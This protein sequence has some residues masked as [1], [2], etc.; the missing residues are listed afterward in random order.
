MAITFKFFGDPALTTE[1]TA[2]LTFSQSTPSPT[3]DD[4]VVYFGSA[5][6]G[7]TVK[8]ASDPGVDQ[9]VVSISDS[10]VGSGSPASDVKLSLTY[11]GLATATAGAPLN[12]GA[13]VSSGSTN[14]KTV[15][16]RV[17]DSSGVAGVNSDLSLATNAL[18]E[19]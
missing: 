14:A 9:I 19:T 18:E 17:L 3:P 7:K 8:A 1:I 5:A 13:Q 16:M 15:H 10:A 4:K 12:L 2:P 11:A 6:S